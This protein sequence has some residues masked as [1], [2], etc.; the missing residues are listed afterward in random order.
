L[1]VG[2]DD[3]ALAKLECISG[4][5]DDVKSLAKIVPVDLEV[6]E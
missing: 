2:P 6:L 1:P 4:D 5:R 3:L